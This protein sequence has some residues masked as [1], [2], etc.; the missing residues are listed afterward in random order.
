MNPNTHNSRAWIFYCY[1]SFAVAIGVTGIGIW[2]MDMS[3]PM[4]AFMS[5]GLLFTTGSAFTLAKT[6]RDEHES[7][8][9]HNKLE[10]AKTE[11]LL[12]EVEA[13]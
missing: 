9:F 1:V 10:D 12:R 3:L 11:R 2:M 5:M 6:L 7:L 8:L 4:K 13:A